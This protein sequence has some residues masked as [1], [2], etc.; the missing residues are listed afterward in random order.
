MRGLIVFV[1]AI[2]A[3][4]VLLSPRPVGAEDVNGRQR[5][6][7]TQDAFGN[8]VVTAVSEAGAPLPVGRR[9]TG[10]VTCR[11]FLPAVPPAGNVDFGQPIPGEPAAGLVEGQWYYLPCGNAD[12]ALVREAW[13]VWTPADSAVMARELALQAADEL[14]VPYPVPGLSPRIGVDQ[15]VGL[16]TWL[17][18]EPGSWQELSATAAIPGLSATVVARPVRTRWDMGDG[19][20]QIVCDGPGVVFDFSRD[21]RL[22]HTDCSHVYQWGSADE[23]GGNYT[24]TGYIDW[25]LTWT[26]TNGDGGTLAD[27]SRGTSLDVH[28]AEIEAVICY[29]N[30]DC[31]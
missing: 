29:G 7:A 24:I 28:A 30:V 21:E 5:T 1:V 18:V 27:A 25:A 11:W 6:D 15:I 13:R 16:P 9:P 23:P 19:S 8:A 10:S 3:V 4:S 2:T 17:W 31:D 22:Q 26:A 20:D 14:V 12:G